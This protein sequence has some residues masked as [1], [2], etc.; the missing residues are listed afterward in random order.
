MS[1][2]EKKANEIIEKFKFVSVIADERGWERFLSTK[3]AKQCALIHV[4]GIIEAYPHKNVK[5]YYVD[6]GG[7]ETN[8]EYFETE[9]NIEFW[10]K[11]KEI[12]T[13]K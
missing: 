5:R 1:E 6:S 10:K 2:E 13:N 11:V 9:S 12:I 7:N 4:D 3:E 8:D